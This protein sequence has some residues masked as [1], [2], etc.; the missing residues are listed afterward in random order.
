MDIKPSN[1]IVATTTEDT[2]ASTVLSNKFSMTSTHAFYR[3]KPSES[4]PQCKSNIE[5]NY[6][7]HISIKDI[8][9]K[10]V[11]STRKLTEEA[12]A[13]WLAPQFSR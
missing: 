8:I 1:T 7:S 13:K 9:G 3:N 4:A 2:E 6:A 5:I 12:N 10:Q 11:E